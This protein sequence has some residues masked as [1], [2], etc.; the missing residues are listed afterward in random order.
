MMQTKRNTFVNEFYKNCYVLAVA[1]Y[2]PFIGKWT[3]KALIHWKRRNEEH[4]GTLVDS[5]R[6]E[7][8]QEAEHHALSL[9]HDWADE[10]MV[11]LIPSPISRTSQESIKQF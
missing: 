4:V 6:F 10:Q 3:P 1:S 2:D 8:N 11:E 7:T 5:V 9:A